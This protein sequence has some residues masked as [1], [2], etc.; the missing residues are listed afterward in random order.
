MY[1]NGVAQTATGNT[2]SNAI[3]AP[4]GPQWGFHRSDTARY[5]DDVFMDQMRISN[6]ARYTGAFTPSTTPF[7]TDV[8]TKLLI[9][10]DFSE[11]GLGADHSSNY[12]Y[13]TPTN[14]GVDDM[15]LDSPMNNFS[16]MN[17]ISPQAH[18]MSEGNLWVSTS[19]AE[20]S[21]NTFGMDSG[22]WYFEV[23]PDSSSFTLGIVNDPNIRLD[24]TSAHVV[25]AFNDGGT[26]STP[27]STEG[28]DTFSSG[29][30][31][32]I[33]GFAIDADTK[34]LDVY[35]NNTKVIEVTSFTIDAPYF[36]SVDRNSGITVT[37]KMNFGADSSFAGTVTEQGNQDGNNKGDFYYTPPSGFLALCADNLS[38]PSISGVEAGENFN[39]ILYTGTGGTQSIA[40]VGF[41]PDWVWIK[42][43]STAQNNYSI[44]SVRGINNIIS[45]NY[46]Y[47]EAYF[48]ATW[49]GLYGNVSAIDS[50]GFTVV[51]G[52]DPTYDSF[53][54]STDTYAS[55][56]W[57]AGG[58]ATSNGDGSITSSVSANTTSGFSIVSYTGTG[59]DATVGHG[60]SSALELLIVKSRDDD[61]NWGVWHEG[62]TSADYALQLN[63][64]I[65]QAN[66]WDYWNDTAP[67]SSV[68]YLGTEL[69]SNKVSST[70]IAYCFHSI[71]GYS[72]VGSYE[73]NGNADGSFI[74]TGFRPAFIMAKRSSATE[75]W[76]IMDNKRNTYNWVSNRLYPDLSNAEGS[77]ETI[78]FVSNGFKM[79]STNS[80]TNAAS[81]YIYLAFAESPF[82]YSNAR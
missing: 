61:Y 32:D 73:G 80:I 50:N 2:S 77:S 48:D 40:G 25:C 62:L 16:T 45:Q 13:F 41:Q 14:L 8:N 49:R 46:A 70:Y 11:G 5:L 67:S 59:S 24:T 52:T 78:D 17:P 66:T 42:A 75:N 74:Y 56:N 54:G 39:T 65:A 63:T 26:V 69:G 55:W 28:S 58:A 72:K 22:K 4:T 31:G 27:N 7:V 15:M 57:K 20:S 44:D 34:T 43:R 76:V 1:I 71:E 53:N 47:G 6:S 21:S 82:K 60:L 3:A 81:T 64:T 33:Y 12:N 18:P 37:E 51:D 23:L 19:V 36:F 10:S 35:Q 38:E 29:G 30:S 68:F 9:Q 79:R